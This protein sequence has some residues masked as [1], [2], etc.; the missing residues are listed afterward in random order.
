MQVN[1]KKG[2]LQIALA[3]DLHSVDQA[4]IIVKDFL[5]Q[6]D[7]QQQQ[8]CIMLGV[9][10]ALNNAVV[11]G[12]KA[13]QDP[14]IFLELNLLPKQV[15]LSVQDQ[16]PGFDWQQV[17]Q[18]P[19]QVDSEHGRGLCIMRSYFDHIFYNARGN[20]VVMEL[21]LGQAS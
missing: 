9:R 11:H 6:N 21:N 7:L 17:M 8:F 20:K 16:G 14:E 4:C 10:E 2:L 3:A 12:S 15:R 1:R 13:C 5:Q 19:L 18:K